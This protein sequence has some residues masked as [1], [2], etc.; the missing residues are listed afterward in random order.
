MVVVKLVIAL[1]SGL[2]GLSSLTFVLGLDGLSP[3]GVW[4]VLGGGM[5]MELVSSRRLLICEESLVW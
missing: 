3:K 1:I 4:H 5:G 2:E